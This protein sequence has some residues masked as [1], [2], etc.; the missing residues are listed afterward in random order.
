MWI[1]SQLELYQLQQSPHCA[2]MFW[3][4]WAMTDSPLFMKGGE[5][6]EVAAVPLHHVRPSELV[7][8]ETPEFC[9]PPWGSW[10]SSLLGWPQAPPVLHRLYS[11]PFIR[12]VQLFQKVAKNSLPGLT[13][14]PKTRFLCVTRLKGRRHLRNL[15][16]LISKHQTLLSVITWPGFL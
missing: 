6:G 14:S 2:F 10:W 13:P 11:F 7:P 3:S 1:I 8:Q 5:Q 12:G 9:V 16:N 4:T 15:S